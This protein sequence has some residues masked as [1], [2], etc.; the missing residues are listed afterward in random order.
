[1]GPER[2]P[3][4][5]NLGEQV[6]PLVSTKNRLKNAGIIA[7]LRGQ[8][9]LTLFHRG[10]AL[11]KIGC[12]AIEVSLDSKDALQIIQRLRTELPDTVQIGVGTILERNQIQACAKAGATFALS[13]TFPE[14]MIEDCHANDILAIPGVRN[15]DELHIAQNAGAQIV[16]LFPS[17]EWISEELDDVEIPW[18]PVGSIDNESIWTWL[19]A[20][21]WCVGMG[22]NLC[23]SDLSQ[24]GIG[25]KDWV[26]NEAQLARDIFMELQHRQNAT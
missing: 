4:S 7:I 1:M 24:E 18:I 3:N 12:T 15:L 2:E 8:N 23:G 5:D 6:S 17:T 19:D 25:T 13:P 22:A 26:G 21:A 9:P 20:G 11:A 10:I 14:G 16:K